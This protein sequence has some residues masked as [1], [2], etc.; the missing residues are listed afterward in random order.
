MGYPNRIYDSI[1]CRYLCVDGFIFLGQ[2]EYQQTIFSV[3]RKK[4]LDIVL[5][6]L[7]MANDDLFQIIV[8][9]LIRQRLNP[10]Y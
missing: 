8:I 6:P 10:A 4:F 2:T 1:S 9:L 5:D 3:E 7:L